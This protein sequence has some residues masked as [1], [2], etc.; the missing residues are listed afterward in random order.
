M[1]SCKFF[2]QLT[3]EDGKEIVEKGNGTN[4]TEKNG[5]TKL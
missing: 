5:Q 2:K 1:L 4:E 3:V